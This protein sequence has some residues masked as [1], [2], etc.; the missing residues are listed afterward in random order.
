MGTTKTFTHTHTHV[1]N[2]NHLIAMCVHIVITMTTFVYGYWSSSWK[3]RNL[4]KCSCFW[5]CSYAPPS[6]RP[7]NRHISIDKL[8]NSIKI[9]SHDLMHTDEFNS[10]TI[11]IVSHIWMWKWNCFAAAPCTVIS[12][13]IM[14]L[15]A[16][17][18]T[19][20]K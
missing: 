7:S 4:C 8:T 1:P 20:G 18:G 14:V 12:G 5:M 13:Q 2:R 17:K 11:S 10:K 3:S 16:K 15:T 19:I 6:E 9:N